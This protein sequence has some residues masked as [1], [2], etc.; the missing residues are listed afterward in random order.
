[1]NVGSMRKSFKDS[2]KVLEADIQHANTLASDLRREYDGGSV[3]MR[4]SYSCAAQFLLFFVYV[5]GTTTM[6]TNERKASI[7]EFYG[8]IYP[9]LMQLQSG[10]SNSEDR[11]QKKICIERRTR[12][13]SCPFC[14]VSLKRIDP[15]ELWVYVDKKEA[16]DMATITR[17]NLKRFFMYVD[18]LPL[19]TS[20]SLFNAYE[21][22]LR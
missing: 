19:V 8:T 22:H 16:I 6:S 11:K 1:M 18:K 9:S 20:D 4:M 5:D 14:R 2:L 13:L 15:D 21:S 3:Q 10:V 17:E 7:R 12:S